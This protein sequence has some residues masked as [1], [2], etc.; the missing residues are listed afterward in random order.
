MIPALVLICLISAYACGLRWGA[1]AVLSWSNEF[2]PGLSQGCAL[3]QDVFLYK[4]V[5]TVLWLHGLVAIR[6]ESKDYRGG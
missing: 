1:G 2:V 5:A 3:E 6:H 4:G